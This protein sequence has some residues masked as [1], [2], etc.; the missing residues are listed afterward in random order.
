MR[1]NE[2]TRAAI[3]E[4]CHTYPK[5]QI[6]DVFKFLHQSTFGCEH[7]VSDCNAA[8]LYV[9]REF[10]RC[11]ASCTDAVEAL[12]GDYS[13]VHL[14]VIRNGI[15]PK[16]LGALFCE[17]A[18]CEK[19][20]LQALENKLAVFEAL[21]KE[22]ELSFEPEAVATAISKWRENCFCALHHSDTFRDEYR[23]AYRV[24]SNKFLPFLPL[25]VRIDAMLECGRVT[26]A[27]EGGSASGKSTLAGMLSDIYDCTVF[28]MDDFFLRPEQ[29]TKE[30]LSEP[31]GNVDRERFF[32][33]VASP[34][35]MGQAVCYRRFDCSTFTLSEPIKVEPKPL[36][37]VEGAYSM[38]P[39]LADT[40]NLSVFL[41]VS[42]E[43]Q[44]KRIE[45]RNSPEMV[46]RFFEEWIPLERAYFDA[47]SIKDSCDICTRI[48]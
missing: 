18:K 30:R 24:I 1:D 35:K 6:E 5:I 23:P 36:T 46:K 43:L 45:K 7:M 32:D 2:K 44:K 8:V 12:D 3:L 26:L 9:E 28:Q 25:F 33:E 31:G 29:R 41:D 13:R 19:A 42:P 16:T 15:S 27:I 40:Y 17:S 37:V 21:V 38:H 34:L 22:G 11:D 4:H 47:F 20:D 48:K 39:S 10:G 14:G